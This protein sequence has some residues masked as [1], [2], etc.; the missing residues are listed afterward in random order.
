MPAHLHPHLP[1]TDA[2]IDALQAELDT[3]RHKLDVTADALAKESKEGEKQR[4]YIAVLERTVKVRAEEVG[5][6]GQ[7]QMLTELARLRGELSACAKDLEA[8][9]EAGQAMQ[10]ELASLRHEV[11][12]C[13]GCVAWSP[14]R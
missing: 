9:E 1:T 6:Q 3:A 11:R 13:C 14:C 4:A 8:R 5:L 10:T 7:G 2:K 12:V